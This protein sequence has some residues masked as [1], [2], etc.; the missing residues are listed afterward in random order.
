MFDKRVKLNIEPTQIIFNPIVVQRILT[1]FDIKPDEEL[2]IKS[3]SIFDKK[4]D[5]TSVYFIFF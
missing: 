3:K 2:V 1:I 5:E 4:I